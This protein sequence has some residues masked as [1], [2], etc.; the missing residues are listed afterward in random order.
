[1][2]VETVADVV[3]LII[4]L[5]VIITATAH[6]AG[7]PILVSSS[8]DSMS[9]TFPEGQ[10][11]FLTRPVVGEIEPG[12]MIIYEP[13]RISESELIHHRVVN[14]TERGFVTKGDANNLTDQAM[15]EPPVRKQ[16]VLAKPI[17]LNNQVLVIPFFRSAK[18]FLGFLTLS[19]MCLWISVRWRDSI[20]E[21]V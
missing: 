13:R 5:F 15:G 6:A 1:M 17:V 10:H 8:G 2:N 18:S 19:A 9:P 20:T 21:L 11:L 16:Q 3:L 12:D 14:V 7:Y 4:S